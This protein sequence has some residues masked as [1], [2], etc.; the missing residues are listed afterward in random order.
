[1][2]D[3]QTI[4]VTEQLLPNEDYSNKKQILRD[5][6]EEINDIDEDIYKKIDEIIIGENQKGEIVEALLSE[7]V[8]MRREYMLKL[9][10]YLQVGTIVNNFTEQVEDMKQQKLTITYENTPTT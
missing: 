6:L 2:E 1:M 10:T 4:T 7:K 3:L 5:Y 8:L 9:I